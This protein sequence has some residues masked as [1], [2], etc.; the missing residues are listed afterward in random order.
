MTTGVLEELS[1]TAQIH[2]LLDE[3]APLDLES[4]PAMPSFPAPAAPP[5]TAL[6]RWSPGTLPL[7]QFLRRV[8]WEN[9]ADYDPPRPEW[10]GDAVAAGPLLPGEAMP[11]CPGAVPLRKF[12]Q[13]VNWDNRPEAAPL[14]TFV[15]PGVA[16]SA[17][18]GRIIETFFDHF[19]FE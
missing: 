14:P 5:V 8:N 6:V 2:D 16:R 7:G 10:L 19:G 18:G 15:A 4:L 1:E 9:R 17:A 11:L 13:L 12:L 3:L